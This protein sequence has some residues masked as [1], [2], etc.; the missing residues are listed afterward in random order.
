MDHIASSGS[1]LH[2][3]SFSKHSFI[4]LPNGGKSQISSIGSEKI[5][6]KTIIKE[7]LHAPSFHVNLLSVSKITRA[8]S[9]SITF[10]LDFCLSQDISTKRTI[11]LR[12]QHNGL[13]Y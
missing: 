4:N 6:S 12:R 11:G 8:F 1:L 13:N 3:T 9:C 10:F 5:G 7:V 2:K